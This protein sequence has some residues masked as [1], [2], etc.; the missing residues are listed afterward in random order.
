MRAKCSVEDCPNTI[1]AKGWCHKHYKRWQ[2]HGDPLYR[3]VRQREQFC[4]MDGCSR[5]AQTKNLCTMHYARLRRWGDPGITKKSAV[6]PTGE[7]A[8]RKV[9][10]QYRVGAQ[11]RDIEMS[12]TDEEI[13]NISQLNCYYCDTPPSQIATSN[14]DTGDFVYNGIDRLDNSKGYKLDNVVPCCWQCNQWKRAM[15]R[16]DFIEHAAKIFETR[17]WATR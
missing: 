1:D 12:M 10:R 17:A 2:D 6:L 14:G 16:L 9:I 5:L 15:P 8:R 11:T 3:R 4:V 13:I 7:A